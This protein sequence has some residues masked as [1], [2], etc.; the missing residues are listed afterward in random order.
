M[1][2]QKP[3]V[4]SFLL[5]INR[6]NTEN[7]S[8]EISRKKHFETKNKINDVAVIGNSYIGCFITNAKAGFEC[9]RNIK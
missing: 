2:A 5:K 7:L 1:F 3:W 6:T 4:T 8:R 9:R